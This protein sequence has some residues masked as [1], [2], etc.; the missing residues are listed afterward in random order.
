MSEM[1]LEGTPGAGRL[2]VLPISSAGGSL[3]E[4]RIFGFSDPPTKS[5]WGWEAE[6]LSICSSA[7]D[8]L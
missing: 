2:H 8:W 1:S 3:E 6:V 4:T 7:T 5:R